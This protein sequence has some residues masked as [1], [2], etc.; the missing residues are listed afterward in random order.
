MIETTFI[1][2]VRK[3][4]TEVHDGTSTGTKYV[5]QFASAILKL[6]QERSDLLAKIK[7]SESAIETLSHKN[8]ELQRKLN[9]RLMDD[10]SSGS[11]TPPRT[12]GST[13]Q[14][15][16]W[17]SLFGGTGFKPSDFFKS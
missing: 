11:G 15:S 1:E 3:Q 9:A 10:L 17:D 4:A 16:A 7:D 2:R 6:L 14:Q 13:D 8:T 5:Q 12:Q